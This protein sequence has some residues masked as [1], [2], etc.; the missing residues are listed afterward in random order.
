MQP[1]DIEISSTTVTMAA[2]RDDATFADDGAPVP[3]RTVWF[4]ALSTGLIVANIYY[5][6]R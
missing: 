2:T 6:Q 1:A 4:M 5:A 3:A